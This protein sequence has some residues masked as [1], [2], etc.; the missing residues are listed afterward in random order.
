MAL[1]TTS[2]TVSLTIY[3]FPVV[4]LI[5]VSGVFSTVS[6]NSVRSASIVAVLHGKTL[7][8]REVLGLQSHVGSRRD[9]GRPGIGVEQLPE[10]VWVG[11]LVSG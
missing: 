10:L 2:S 7:Q 8:L 3:F 11:L 9:R 4:R 6:I 1:E 5:I